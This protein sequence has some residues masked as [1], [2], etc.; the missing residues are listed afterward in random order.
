MT[1]LEQ[2]QRIEL[3]DI[4]VPVQ[5]GIVNDVV[6]NVEPI[7][8]ITNFTN[9]VPVT[10]FAKF[11]LN[12]YPNP[13]DFY[14]NVSKNLTAAIFH[15]AEIL[16]LAG[17]TNSVSVEMIR[18]P[19]SILPYPFVSQSIQNANGNTEQ[20]T[21]LTIKNLVIPVQGGTIATA[22]ISLD[23]VDNVAAFPDITPLAN[24]SQSYLTTYGNPND[25][26]EKVSQN[27]AA[28]ISNN[29]GAFGLQGILNSVSV[30]LG[31]GPNAALPHP[32]VVTSIAT[33][34]GGLD[35]IVKVEI[36][37]LFVPVQGG[38]VN[39]VVL[40]IDYANSLGTFPDISPVT[41]FVKSFLSDYPNPND[42]YENISKNV[43]TAIFNNAAGLGLSGIIDSISIEL[44]RDPI[45]ILP[46]SFVSENT[47]TAAGNNQQVVK[48][49]LEDLLIPVQGGTVANGTL[50]LDFVDNSESF[51]DIT[52]LA[53]FTKDYL[54]NY[55]NP[56]DF[57]EN[58]SQ[59]LTA[60]VVN[61]AG[62]FGLEGKIDSLS[63]DLERGPNA[64]LPHPFIS[65]STAIPIAPS[66]PV[67]ANSESFE[68]F[69][70][71][72]ANELAII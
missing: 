38:T 32:F 14:E 56:N 30:E 34:G 40:T 66:N 33:P 41:N 53:N 52:T 39:D 6:I 28:T 60:T 19:I 31:R 48:L 25:F 35:Q 3:E 42:F 16:G 13:N 26:Y 23:F 54:T 5:G 20:F 2:S 65:T 45:A 50:T 63:L 36:E 47:I 57:Y 51:P 37:D 21:E 24:F 69:P 44:S 8:G 64:G 11:F 12:N 4:F 71:D 17:K 49:E 62:A 43:T 22:N 29:P 9:I 58:V 15:N 59:N 46:Y 55:P 61:N 18:E 7:S 68:I 27:L 67:L 1:S 70:Q 72:F 10:N